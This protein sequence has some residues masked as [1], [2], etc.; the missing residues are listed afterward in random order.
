MQI[1]GEIVSGSGT[2]WALAYNPMQ[3]TVALYASG[4]RIEAGVGNDYTIDASGNIT[5]TT[6][7]SAGMLTADYTPQGSAIVPLSGPAILPYAL[8]SLQRVKDRIFDPNKTIAL[9]GASLTATS[10]VVTGI[11]VAVG[12]KLQAG[13]QIVGAGIPSGTTV[14]A[15]ISASEILLSANATE[16]NTGQTLYVIDQPVQF[17][18]LLTA[19]INRVTD[20]IERQCGG[21]RF[22]STTYTNEVYTAVGTRQRQ[23]ALRQFP[24]TAYTSFQWR[25]GIPSNPQWTDFLIDQ[26]ELL[27][28][29]QDP[30]TGGTVWRTGIVHIYGSVP[31][32]TVNGIR[33]SYTAGY[34]TDWNN[35]GN[36]ALHNLPSDLSDVAANLV[37]RVFKRRELAGQNS[38]AFSGATDGWRN[39]LDQEDLDVIGSYKRVPIYI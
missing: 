18:G 25:E 19:M 13:Q 32:I 16:T 8:T 17:D 35:E 27:D 2:A 37:V 4:V 22:V 36:P 21:R 12:R 6:S 39:A 10:N 24:V 9:T 26:Y 38:K 14:G 1:V 11:T 15:V 31:S 5:T 28:S 7:Y 29:Y 34:L 20:Y 23:I 3:N 33:I 30:Y